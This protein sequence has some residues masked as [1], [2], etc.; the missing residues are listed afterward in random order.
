MESIQPLS[1]ADPGTKA[2]WSARRPRSSSRRFGQSA[3]TLA[4]RQ[5]V[6]GPGSVQ[7]TQL[8]VKTG[9][10]A[11]IGAGGQKPKL[12]KRYRLRKA[13]GLNSQAYDPAFSGNYREILSAEADHPHRGGARLPSIQSS[14]Q[15][16]ADH[17]CVGHRW[18]RSQDEPIGRIHDRGA[19][20]P[21]PREL[22]KYSARRRR[23]A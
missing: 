9:R 12:A 20:A 5:T 17:I 2:S 23:K 11:D 14:S 7:L 19:N 21:G 3:G 22:R 6:S 16:R 15:N 8:G 10:K 1:A 4:D 18:D 13:D